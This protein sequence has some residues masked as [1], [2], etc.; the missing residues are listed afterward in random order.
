MAINLLPSL[1]ALRAFEVVSR[2]LSYHSAA[3]ELN[4]TPAAVKQLVA[5]LEATVGDKLLERV[6]QRIVLTKRGKDCCEELSFGFSHIFSSVEK[7]RRR[8]RNDELII[9]VETSFAATWLVPKLNQFRADYPDI[10][11]LIDSNQQIVDLNSGQADI[12]VRYGVP[13][14]AGQIVHR[15]FDDLIFPA[16]SPNLISAQQLPMP[17]DRLSDFTLIHWNL[18]QLAWASETHRWFTWDQWL[19]KLSID[20]ANSHNGISFSDYGQAVQAAI[21]GQG[22]VLASWPILKEAF[23]NGLLIAPF[24]EQLP[25]DIGYDLVIMPNSQKRAEVSAFVDWIIATA[26]EEPGV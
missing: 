14:Q 9:T 1:N 6:G 5:K 22:I 17:I 25:T 20:V 10:N 4:V 26:D 11:V 12:A 13:R 15:L 21:A 8:D 23:D 7:M 16:C 18:S 3:S 2:H 19:A 24:E